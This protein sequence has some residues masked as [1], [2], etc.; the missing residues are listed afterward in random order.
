[1]ELLSRP[2]SPHRAGCVDTPQS[3]HFPSP[4]TLVIQGVSIDYVD[5]TWDVGVRADVE[6]VMGELWRAISGWESFEMIPNK[7]YINGDRSLFAYMQTLSNGCVTMALHPDEDRP[8]AEIPAAEWLGHACA[9]LSTAG[10]Q[11]SD[12]VRTAAVPGSAEAWR[13]AAHMACR[14]RRFGVTKRGYW[15]LGPGALAEGDIVCVLLGGKTPFCLRHY[16]R[17]HVLVGECY[18]H[19]LMNGEAIEDLKKGE[20]METSFLIR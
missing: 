12:D 16:E 20:Y 13:E 11:V 2:S 10:H 17:D 4:E 7:S 1:M 9:Y 18:V 5:K 8:Y 15:V 3:L 19:G 6:E 14:G